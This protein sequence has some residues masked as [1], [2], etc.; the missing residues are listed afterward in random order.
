METLCQQGTLT[1]LPNSS[2][3]NFSCLSMI[4][5]ANSLSDFATFL[6]DWS[7]WDSYITDGLPYESSSVVKRASPS[8]MAL[9]PV[10]ISGTWIAEESSNV[11][12]S[13]EKFNR[14]INNMTLAMP[15]PVSAEAVVGVL[16]TAPGDFSI[17]ALNAAVV[18]PS[19][20]VLCANANK[21]E[22]APLVYSEWPRARF[23]A[24]QGI[25]ESMIPWD[26]WEGDTT[27]SFWP[28]LTAI[29][30]VF[31]WKAPDRRPPIFSMVRD[32]DFHWLFFS[33]SDW[34]E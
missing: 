7:Y 13:F 25:G 29:D 15:Y 28:N 24:D 20:N 3:A 31:E 6:Q 23:T 19:S 33:P 30:D 21:S 14:I 27:T 32:K 10:T 17:T 9:S 2:D 11:T 4:Q 1:Q 18:S 12:S 5:N 26:G 34:R 22:I 16:E 8:T